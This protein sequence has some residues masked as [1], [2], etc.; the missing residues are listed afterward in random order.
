MKQEHQSQGLL[1]PIV[2][3]QQLAAISEGHPYRFTLIDRQPRRLQGVAQGLKI[4]AQPRQAS[5]K[6]GCCDLTPTGLTQGFKGWATSPARRFGPPLGPSHLGAAVSAAAA[7]L[8]DQCRT[9]CASCA[10]GAAAT[11]EGRRKKDWV[12]GNGA[13]HLTRLDGWK[14][15]TPE[16]FT[17]RR[18]TQKLS[19]TFGQARGWTSNSS[20]IRMGLNESA[21]RNRHPEPAA[22]TSLRTPLPGSG[23]FF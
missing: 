5:L 12:L 6:A 23:V 7:G 19:V 3:G 8:M 21:E 13:S 1:T 2:K 20:V 9:P 14:L 18:S 17:L 22:N 11:P 16:Q 10:P 15:V 4:P